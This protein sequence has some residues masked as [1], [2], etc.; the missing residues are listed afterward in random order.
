MSLPPHRQSPARESAIEPMLATVRETRNH[1]FLEWT[2]DDR[3]RH[4]SFVGV[5][6]DRRAGKLG[7]K[8]AEASE[9]GQVRAKSQQSLSLRVCLIRR[10]V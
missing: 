3:L 10:E 2:L 8:D 4:P 6:T 7:G 9:T 5:S 1:D